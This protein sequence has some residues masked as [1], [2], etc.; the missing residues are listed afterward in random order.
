MLQLL[1]SV[2]SMAPPVVT[3]FRNQALAA[4]LAFAAEGMMADSAAS[5]IHTSEDGVTKRDFLA[6]VAGFGA[7][8]LVGAI[9]W[10]LVDSMNPAADTL[11]VSAVEV[12]LKPIA[13]GSGI[14][15]L[16]RGQPV[17]VRH[18]TTAEIASAQL[19]STIEPALDSDRVKAGHEQWLVLIAVCTHLGCIPLGN[20]AGEKRGDWGGYYCPCH[21][22]QYDT[23]GR[24]RHGPAPANLA[25]PPY[26]FETDTKIKIG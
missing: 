14:T 22:S 8:I 20:K 6:L 26:A 12:D 13:L 18:R 24:V 4:W 21:G 10:P 1:W 2:H 17:F 16:W 23:S 5:A 7:V 9:A 25:V 15:L 3:E 19:P 11:A